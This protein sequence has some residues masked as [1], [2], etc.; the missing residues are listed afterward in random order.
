MI[1][2]VLVLAGSCICFNSC[3][4][5]SSGGSDNMLLASVGRGGV[6]TLGGSGGGGAISSLVSL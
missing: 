6:F 3:T 5:D 4:S 1:C 2:D